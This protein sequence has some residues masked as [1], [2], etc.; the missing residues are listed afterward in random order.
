MRVFIAI[1][2]NQDTQ[3]ALSLCQQRLD[4]SGMDI[5]WIQ[6]RNIHLTLKF[7]GEINQKNIDSISRALK[8]TLADTRGFEFSISGIGA[9][10]DINRP[11]V[12]WAGIGQGKDKCIALQKNIE[13]A[14]Q[15]FGFRKEPRAFIPHLTLARIKT[16]RDLKKIT[17][18]LEKEHSYSIN[19][20]MPV[21]RV[22]LFC[23]LPGR[24]E[25]IYTALEEFP[26]AVTCG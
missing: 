7:F 13:S 22:V 20:K 5:R 24:K 21:N 10:P 16:S 25:P 6:P 2:L 11:R 4:T 14:L 15:A 18:L 8:K 12:I 1:P 9:F 19:A 26:I 17:M 3:T 23:S